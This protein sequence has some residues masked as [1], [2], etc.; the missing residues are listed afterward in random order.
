MSF[1]LNKSL[2]FHSNS[3]IFTISLF[4]AG[5]IIVMEITAQLISLK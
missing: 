2:S 5:L 3:I 1:Y 4:Y